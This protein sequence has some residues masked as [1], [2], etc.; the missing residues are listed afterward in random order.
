MR[1][2]QCGALQLNGN[3]YC[4]ACAAPLELGAVPRRA[5]LPA[6]PAVSPQSRRLTALILAAVAFLLLIC[7]GLVVAGYG[8]TALIDWG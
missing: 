8:L 3:G 2:G 1:C 5:T 4:W 6:S 7:L